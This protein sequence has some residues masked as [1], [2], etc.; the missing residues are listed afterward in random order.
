MPILIKRAGTY[1]LAL[2][3]ML[4][5]GSGLAQDSPP[6]AESPAAPAAESRPD[7]A[8]ELVQRLDDVSRRLAEINEYLRKPAPDLAGIAVALPGKAQE[9]QSVLGAVEATDPS[10]A[11]VVEVMATLQ[12]LRNLDRI[13]DKWRRRLKVEVDLLDPWR[14]ELRADAGF[15]REVASPAGAGAD[16]GERD[17]LSSAVRSRL[18]ELADQLDATRRPLLKRLDVIV[19][20]D[21]RVGQ[22]QNSLRELQTQLDA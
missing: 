21:V 1:S 4:L 15:L 18:T 8:A 5:T 6:A 9:A 16:A 7:T 13:F 17:L 12:K 10:Q 2:G 11:E 20:A 22:L 3:L 19:G 14:E